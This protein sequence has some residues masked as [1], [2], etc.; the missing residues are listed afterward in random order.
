MKIIKLALNIEELTGKV[1]EES[2]NG[3]LQMLENTLKKEYIKVEE[4]ANE[5]GI[6]MEE[7]FEQNIQKING[8]YDKRGKVKKENEREER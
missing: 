6:T 8:R 3:N 4:I 7:I 2:I 1:V 5:I